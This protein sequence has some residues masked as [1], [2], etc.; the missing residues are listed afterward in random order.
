MRSISFILAGQM[1]NTDDMNFFWMMLA[2]CK[3]RRNIGTE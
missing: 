1:R 3:N 2:K